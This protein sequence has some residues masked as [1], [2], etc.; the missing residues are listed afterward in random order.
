ML[1]ILKFALAVSLSNLYFSSCSTDP[2]VDQARLQKSSRQPA[3][4]KCDKGAS[5]DGVY[6]FKEALANLKLKKFD[7][8]CKSFIDL[9]NSK[10]FNLKAIALIHGYE[11]CIT[12]SRLPNLD[13]FLKVNQAS[14]I[15]NL[16]VR[17]AL[18]RSQNLH[19]EFFEYKITLLI[20][21]D[22]IKHKSNMQSENEAFIFRAL[23]LLHSHSKDT[24]FIKVASEEQLKNILYEIAPR[25]M[26]NPPKE[27]L[28][29]AARDIQTNARPFDYPA[30]RL[31]YQK[32]YELNKSDPETQY[33]A[34]DSIRYTYKL[35]RNADPAKLFESS[36]IARDFC[37]KNLLQKGAS[38]IWPAYYVKASLLYAS[39]LWT[40]EKSDIGRKDAT[41][42]MNDTIKNLKLVKS[43]YSI[44][45]LVLVKARIADENG[46]TELA[47]KLLQNI[48]KTTKEDDK[49]DQMLWTRAFI[50]YKAGRFAEAA[51]S[52]SEMIALDTNSKNSRAHFWRAESLK[53]LSNKE[54]STQSLTKSLNLYLP[55]FNWIIENDPFSY[56]GLVAYRELKMT[57]PS[58]DSVRKNQQDRKKT[59]DKSTGPYSPFENGEMLELSRAL[60]IAKDTDFERKLLDSTALKLGSRSS[61]TPQNW[62]DLLKLYAQAEQ[63]QK[64][65]ENLAAMPLETRQQIFADNPELV[66][67]TEP[68]LQQVQ[69]KA[70]ELKLKWEFV[71]SIM[72]QESS[73]NPLARSP[74]NA[75]GLLQLI[76]A[77]AIAVASDV[78]IHIDTHK[79]SDG[80]VQMDNPEILYDPNINI[81]LGMALMKRLFKKNNDNFIKSVAGYNASPAAVDGWIKN[82]YHGDILAFI[83]DIPFDETKIYVKTVMRNFVY[84][85]RLE[86]PSKDIEFPAWCLEGFAMV[87]RSNDS[88]SASK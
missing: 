75:Y 19:D 80:H 69:T 77:N 52:Y 71:F 78:N 31:L 50:Y 25:M 26:P 59:D 81:P 62:V 83:D 47:L 5:C 87:P 39:H 35:A 8:A 1:K 16:A 7:E 60:V 40:F 57:L 84:Y 54:S 67:P 63:Y 76:P 14:W 15:G 88:Y 20:L 61:T 53:Q 3:S 42:L 9:S 43:D 82:R 36:K 45:D 56:Y 2:S 79:D 48:G 73:L 64:L 85:S 51:Q 38:S 11:S 74:A 28:W 46:D 24:K 23:E 72:R 49:R 33:K 6:K 10:D 70:D 86:T 13:D 58:I 12:D 21:E 27:K 44:D 29:L 34:L 18:T 30:A 68:Y 55:D 32:I 37:A 4:F 22:Q 65:F 17:A 66:F 41:D